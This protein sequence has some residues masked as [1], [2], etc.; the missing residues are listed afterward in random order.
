[1]PRGSD[2]DRLVSRAR[3]NLD[4]AMGRKRSLDSEVLEYRRA[5]DVE[6]KNA[7]PYDNAPDITMPLTRSKRD[8]VIAHLLDALDVEPFFSAKALTASAGQIAP[9][10]EAL[11]EREMIAVGAREK[12]LG[13]V[14][15]SVDTGTG[16][17]GWS[18]AVGGDGEV[19]VQESLIRF[20]DFA[21]Y[22]VRVDDNTN[23]STFHRRTEPWFVLDEMANEGLLDREAVDKLKGGSSSEGETH[24]ETRDQTTDGG[25][26]DDEQEVHTYFECYIRFRG[27]LWQVILTR[28]HNDPLAARRNPFREA[29]D[30]PPY[31]PLRIMRNPGYYYGY[32][33]PRLLDA[34]QKMMDTAQLS[35][36][37]YN[38]F[39]LAPVIMADRM[40]P[41]IAELQKGGLHPGQIIPTIGNPNVNGIQPVVFPKPDLTLEE[42]SLAQRFADLASFTDF[43]LQGSPFAASRRTATEV[44]TS[45][46]IGTLK[47]RAFLRTI[48]E[49][50]ARAARKRWALIEYF[51]VRPNGVEMIHRD[52]EAFIISS[53]GIAP[54]EVQ[55]A[56][57]EFVATETGGD[58]EASQQLMA[59]VGSMKSDVNILDV[60]IPSMK[61]SDIRW[62]ANGSDVIP[63]KVAEMQ[64][65]DGFAQ[66]VPLLPAA[67]QDSRI[68]YFLKT[69]LQLMGRHDWKLL[70][71][72]DPQ[73]RNDGAFQN[74][75]VQSLMGGEGGNTQGVE[76]GR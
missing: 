14:S 69:R 10:W 40:N 25:A 51:K 65:L 11:M 6:P 27:E 54:D 43:Q 53:D 75:E 19:F 73:L 15:E 61:R 20:E 45:F 26:F 28:R 58:P 24:A 29:F 22:P 68:W 18:L 63:D 60:G 49:D 8:G 64:K 37:A 74:P 52:S 56:V 16:H 62:V 76:G 38:Q 44:R 34:L 30:A 21:V 66:F 1:M 31:E 32:P 46:N 72:D 41:F 12:Y 4:M 2:L 17:I 48:R 3:N 5:I 23:V 42:L 13:G 35:R 50:L 71:G 7:L 33:F 70:V 59:E 57:Q 67:Q 55:L 47:L 39:A 36:M 9:T